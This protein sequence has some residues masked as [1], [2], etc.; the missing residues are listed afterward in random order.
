[1]LKKERF[2][3]VGIETACSHHLPNPRPDAPIWSFDAVQ[4]RLVEAI[5]YLWRVPGRVGPGEL[6]A[7]S[8]WQRVQLERSDWGANVSADEAPRVRG[9]TR[10]EM[11][12]M[13]EALGWID[14]VPAGDTRQIVAA[15]LIQLA[16]GESRVRWTEVFKAM[17]KRGVHGFTNDGMRKRYGRA[18][19]MICQRLNKGTAQRQDLGGVEAVKP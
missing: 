13:E 19:T 5:T 1:M 15:A 6:R 9:L 11:A 7:S 14:H 4:E 3:S 8:F 16:R 12:E 18:L 2:S 17:E 10:R